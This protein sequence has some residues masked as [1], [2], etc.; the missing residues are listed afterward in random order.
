MIRV[1]L[2]IA[3]PFEHNGIIVYLSV[4][5]HPKPRQSELKNVKP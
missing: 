2:L 1:G 3:N 5:V 4:I